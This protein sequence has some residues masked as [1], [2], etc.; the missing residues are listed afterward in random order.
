MAV[1]KKTINFEQSIDE[2]ES[3]VEALES[4]TLSLEDSLKAFEKGVRITRECQD[5]L[6][7]AEQK[8]SLLSQNSQGVISANAFDQPEE[9]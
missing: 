7:E 6:K 1:R 2:L 9:S 8:I 4:G 5:A 3:L